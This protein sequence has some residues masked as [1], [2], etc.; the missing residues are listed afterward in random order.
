MNRFFHIIH[1]LSIHSHL[2]V[3]TLANKGQIEKAQT[4]YSNLQTV[5][6][7]NVNEDYEIP[8][9]LTFLPKK[10]AASLY[11]RILSYSLLNSANGILLIFYQP[12][13]KLLK[14]S[15][16][17][18]V[19]YENL[20][21]LDLAKRIKQK[22]P[23]IRQVYDAHNFDTEIALQQFQRH[24]IS[25]RIYKNIIKIESSIYKY[26]DILWTCSERDKLLFD[27]VNNN[28]IAQI[29]VI[30][31]G[32]NLV[33]LDIIDTKK[34]KSQNTI[35]FVGSLDYEPNN[36]GLIWFLYF[37]LPH[38]KT[39]VNLKII[40]SGNASDE[41]IS[42]LNKTLNAELIGFVEKLDNDYLDAELVII[43]LLSG[44]GTRLKALEAMNYQRAIISTSKGVEGLDISD[45]VLIANDPSQF[46][47][48]I[49]SVLLDTYLRFSLG[50]KGRQ[51]VED[52]YSWSM[53]GKKI[54]LSL[55]N[56]FS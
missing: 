51:L 56:T 31:N 45:Q 25:K 7:Y 39:K 28:R 9:I 30:P 38:I 1:Q 47:D 49:D 26:I 17:D 33:N 18:V 41:L 19:V 34:E 44:S 6:F 29:D 27:D 4:K 42:L 23:Q 5:S 40:G 13:I 16:Y 48:A 54:K 24:E 37:I 55:I 2:T 21:T 50:T 8:K 10:I 3:L 52:N 35:L 11:S 20:A 12:T 22:F 53:I 32:A 36:E 14:N 46:I 43:P 15:H